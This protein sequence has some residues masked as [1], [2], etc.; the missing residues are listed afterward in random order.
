MTEL[1]LGKYSREKLLTPRQFSPLTP[2]GEKLESVKI[3]IHSAKSDQ[4]TEVYNEMLKD[5]HSMQTPNL[6]R[7]REYDIKLAKALIVKFEGV[8]INGVEYESNAENIEMLVREFDFIRAQAI[9]LAQEDAFF[10]ND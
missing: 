9:R 4:A 6:K 2:T 5:K 7:D 10:F 8:L 1:D 3:W